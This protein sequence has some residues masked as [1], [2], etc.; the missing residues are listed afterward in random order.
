MNAD[1]SKVNTNNNVFRNSTTGLYSS[2][3]LGL[4]YINDARTF[5]ISG[6]ISI[7]RDNYPCIITTPRIRQSQITRRLLISPNNDREDSGFRILD[8]GFRI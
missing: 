2:A 8:F 4:M 7:E 6:H 5:S 1:L 3:A